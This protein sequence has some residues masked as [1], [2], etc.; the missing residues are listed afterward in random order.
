M[1][2]RVLLAGFQNT[3]AHELLKSAT[4]LDTLVFPN[5]MIVDGKLL[6]QRLSAGCY[7]VAICVGQKPGL[8]DKLCIETT[9]KAGNEVFVTAVDCE[10]LASLFSAN[11]IQSKISHRAGTSFCN[12]V[13]LNG[14]RFVTEEEVGTAVIFIHIPYEGRMQDPIAFYSKFL[15]VIEKLRSKEAAYLWTRSKY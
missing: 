5:D 14:L 8:K 6:I 9:A 3:S 7:D 11:G 10:K 4:G 1:E 15:A 2:N 12:E 13:Y